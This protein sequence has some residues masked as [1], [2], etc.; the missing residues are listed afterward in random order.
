MLF[1][2][3]PA[4][5]QT[6]RQKDMEMA[7][8]IEYDDKGKFFT[9]VITKAPKLVTL[10]T[11]THHIHGTAYVNPGERLKDELDK[12]EPFL[13]ITD[14]TIYDQNGDIL[15]ECKFLAVRRVH[16]VWVLPDDEIEEMKEGER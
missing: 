5:N 9:E 6:I 10:Q 4:Y 16:I 2:K 1:A 13:A 14:A 11:V 8:N 3:T 15:H 7:M 12:P